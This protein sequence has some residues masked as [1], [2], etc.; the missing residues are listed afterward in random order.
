MKVASPLVLA[1]A[2]LL[3]LPP[4][5]A[6]PKS[7]PQGNCHLS[8]VVTVNLAAGC[9][10][11][12]RVAP[13]P[14]TVTSGT[15]AII[16]WNIVPANPT[17]WKFDGGDGIQIQGTMTYA[18]GL[19]KTTTPGQHTFVIE[20]QNKGPAAFK[21]DINLVRGTEKCKLDPVIVDW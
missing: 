10:S 4:A 18:K 1:S 14:I 5:A 21:C 7:P 12:I 13:D 3:S 6:Q 19:F 20:H 9:G 11:G 15:T 16:T 17:G 8:C 2:L